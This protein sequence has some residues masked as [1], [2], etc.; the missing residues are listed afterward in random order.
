MIS[1]LPLAW[2][3]AGQGF[4]S[5]KSAMHL[6]RFRLPFEYKW[7]HEH[8]KKLN[9]SRSGFAAAKQAATMEAL[10]NSSSHTASADLQRGGGWSQ[11][12]S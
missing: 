7:D 8:Q 1:W 11:D 2:L 9:E 10:G 3:N 6:M 4:P 12:E 5:A